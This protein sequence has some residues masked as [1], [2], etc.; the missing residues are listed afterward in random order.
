M[1][2]KTR[3]FIT[4]PPL[5]VWSC[6]GIFR[7]ETYGIFTLFYLIYFGNLR[8]LEKYRKFQV[9]KPRN[10]TIQSRGGGLINRRGFSTGYTG[11]G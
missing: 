1:L 4:P 8:H 10:M 9:K 7:R 3:P 5:P 2:K 6:Y 11:T